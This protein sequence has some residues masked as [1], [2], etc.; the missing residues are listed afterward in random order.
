MTLVSLAGHGDPKSS[1]RLA[2]FEEKQ[3][4]EARDDSCPDVT[5]VLAGL[6]RHFLW[7]GTAL[8]IALG[9]ALAVVPHA[10]RVRYALGCSTRVMLAVPTANSDRFEESASPLFR[11]HAP[12]LSSRRWP[13]DATPAHD[14]DG[15]L[16]GAVSLIQ[17]RPCRWNAST[18]RG[19]AGS[20]RMM[21]A[22][23]LAASP[24]CARL[25]ARF[26]GARAAARECVEVG[27]PEVSAGRHAIGAPAGI[28]AS[29]CRSSWGGS[30]RR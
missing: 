14:G 18:L 29:R 21:G 25:Q 22:A 10:A 15:S 12:R 1:P 6:S 7:Q 4:Q 20:C 27:A 9:M 30:G 16:S 8:A 24:G 17:R 28:G 23:L 3:T 2:V 5:S 19:H 26:V 11:P 13:R